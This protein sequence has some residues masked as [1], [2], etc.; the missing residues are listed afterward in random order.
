M[1][2]YTRRPGFVGIALTGILLGACGGSGVVTTTTVPPSTTA[3]TATSTTT[4]PP[5]STTT[6]ATA[7]TVA[8]GGGLVSLVAGIDRAQSA[9]AGEDG[10][11]T[12]AALN[13]AEDIAVAPNG[14]VYIADR[15]SQR[16]LKISDGILTVAYRGSFNGA[17]TT[18]QASTS[19]TMARFT[20]PLGWVFFL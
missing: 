11:A 10:P 15:N 7:T 16:L 9:T 13:N 6:E 14:D 8:T 3:T 20:S 18:S 12:E 1:R 17:R 4:A 2:T 19:A 5:A